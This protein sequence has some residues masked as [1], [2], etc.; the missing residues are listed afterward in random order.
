ME[1]YS[2]AGDS[3]GE[4][5]KKDPFF[6]DSIGVTKMKAPILRITALPGGLS[7]LLY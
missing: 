1:V 2:D 6:F 3:T 5:P 7:L 4:I